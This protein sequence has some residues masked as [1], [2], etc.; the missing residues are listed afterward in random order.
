MSSEMFQIPAQYCSKCSVLKPLTEYHFRNKQA[1]IVRKDCKECCL[2]QKKQHYQNNRNHILEYK[3]RYYQDNRNHILEYMQQYRV[4][5]REKYNEYRRNKYS[6]DDSFRIAD[7]LRRR[8]K[9]IITALDTVHPS[10]VINL[11]GCSAEWLKHWLLYSESFYCFNSIFTHVDHIYPMSAY[12][13]LDPSEQK[14]AMYWKNLRI[15]DARDNESKG[16]KMPTDIDIRIHLQLIDDFYDFM[17]RVHP[18]IRCY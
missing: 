4:D 14:R 13:L 8:M 16:K 5:N 1:G 17:R 15:I 11:M 12:N 9:H 7:N 10:T 18:Y 3:R 6:E 2:K